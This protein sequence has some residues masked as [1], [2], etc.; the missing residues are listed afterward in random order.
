MLLQETVRKYCFLIKQKNLQP[1][2]LDEQNMF[3]VIILGE[4][5]T[6]FWN[7]LYIQIEKIKKK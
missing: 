4:L 2:T 7:F 3:H 5:Y 1:E 6:W